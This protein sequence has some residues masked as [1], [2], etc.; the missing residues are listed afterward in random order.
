MR[1]SQTD[2]GVQRPESLRVPV[3]ETTGSI[4]LPETVNIHP[5]CSI[6][7]QSAYIIREYHTSLPNILNEH[8]IC[9]FS[10]VQK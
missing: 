6:L 8:S 9:V 2:K 4:H 7:K 10:A 1:I 3:E 5:E